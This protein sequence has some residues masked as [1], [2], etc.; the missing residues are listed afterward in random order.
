MRA[1]TFLKSPNNVVYFGRGKYKQGGLDLDCCIDS[2]CCYSESPCWFSFNV[3]ATFWIR[4]K[5]CRFVW[6]NFL[7]SFSV[8]KIIRIWT[9]IVLWGRSLSKWNI[10]CLLKRVGQPIRM[11]EYFYVL[12]Y[13]VQSLP[14]LL[15]TPLILS[16]AFIV[17]TDSS[18]VELAA[19][20]HV[21]HWN[22]ALN[23]RP[24]PAQIA[25]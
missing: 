24:Y 1:L 4:Y 15:S 17:T 20:Y 23:L 2:S 19:Q 3:L 22:F 13:I 14:L 5:H 10:P 18:P 25:A 8:A 21:S 7:T 16:L 11:A 9:R 6:I 12:P